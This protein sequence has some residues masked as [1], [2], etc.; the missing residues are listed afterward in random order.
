[1]T[2][3]A[4]L[5]ENLEETISQLL[6]VCEGLD[7]PEI[8]VYAGWTAK[9]I[10]AHLTFWHESFARNVGDLVHGRKPSP[11]RGKY[12]E[13][14]RRCFA[15]FGPLTQ[16]EILA[17]LIDAHHIIQ[18]NILN[19]TL[20]LIPYRI[21]SRDYSPEEHLQIVADHIHNHTRDIEKVIRADP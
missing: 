16:E 4:E 20:E 10:L 9:D 11:L 1:M 17:R 21:G 13:L 2:T 12:S 19:E 3:R 8:L 5:L 7:N 14:N 6:R 15:E 18:T